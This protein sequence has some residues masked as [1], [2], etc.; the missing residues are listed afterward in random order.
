MLNEIHRNIPVYKPINLQKN[1]KKQVAFG[2]KIKGLENLA[3]DLA[4]HFG[5][6]RTWF[7]GLFG[8]KKAVV[9]AESLAA[10]AKKSA[11]DGY[12]FVIKII[13]SKTPAY[14]DG[15]V[16]KKGYIYAEGYKHTILEVNLIEDSLA[17]ELKAKKDSDPL[18][19]MVNALKEKIKIKILTSDERLLANE[20][21][22]IL[23]KNPETPK[24]FGTLTLAK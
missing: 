11:D 17:A 9:V 12:S 19:Q 8:K 13:K 21:R 1:N 16:S 20:L 4:Q 22:E 3:G 2:T 14:N 5:N 10:S 18:R 7:F 24:I 23:P 15:Y 6:K